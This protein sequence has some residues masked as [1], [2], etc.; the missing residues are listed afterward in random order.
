[1]T[2]LIIDS[3]DLLFAVEENNDMAESYIDRQSGEVLRISLYEEMEE[4][5]ELK[6]RIEATPERYLFIPPVSSGEAW[7]VM[8]D[9]I[10]TVGNEK[11]AARLTRAIHGRG[12]FRAFKDALC[13]QPDERERWFRFKDEQNLK[14]L[15][16][17]LKAEGIETTLH[18]KR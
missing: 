10:E 15:R 13:D 1:M 14:E 11:F 17:W 12:A 18:V 16:D 9:F 6:A 2:K 8:E 7:Q 5:A 3:A 4:E